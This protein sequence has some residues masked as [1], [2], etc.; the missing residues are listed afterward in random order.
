MQ[1]VPPTVRL[2]QVHAAG[3]LSEAGFGGTA[4][5]AGSFMFFA[6]IAALMALHQLMPFFFGKPAL[7]RWGT[8]KVKLSS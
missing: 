6:K 2:P 5:R 3:R 8:V 4:K 7:T 1:L